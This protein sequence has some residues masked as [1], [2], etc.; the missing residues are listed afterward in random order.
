[1]L[2]PFLKELGVQCAQLLAVP[3]IETAG[4][5]VGWGPSTNKGEPLQGTCPPGGPGG[6]I[7]EKGLLSLWFFHV[8]VHKWQG[9]GL[10]SPPERGALASFL[11]EPKAQNGVA[12][13]GWHLSLLIHINRVKEVKQFERWPARAFPKQC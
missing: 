9:N 2:V 1:M 6:Q 3:F 8:V 10:E 11:G 4:W 7:S 12:G 13:A 5:D